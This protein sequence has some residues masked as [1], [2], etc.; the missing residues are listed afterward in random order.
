MVG[1]L[2]RTLFW[3]VKALFSLCP[4]RLKG[5]SGQWSDW[6]VGKGFLGEL[7]WAWSEGRVWVPG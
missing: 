1:V 5:E 6:T 2:V 4:H 7:E 3:V